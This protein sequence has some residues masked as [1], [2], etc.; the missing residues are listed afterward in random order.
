MANIYNDT[1]G[2]EHHETFTHIKSK[3]HPIM[4]KLRNS[5]SE[6]KAHGTTIL[7]LGVCNDIENLDFLKFFPNAEILML[8]SRK[9]RNIDG[10]KHAPLLTLIDI[11]SDWPGV[12]D[13]SPIGNCD[14]LEDLELALTMDTLETGPTAKVTMRG[15]ETLA[16]L[17][18]LSCLALVDM[19]LT[20]ISFVKDMASL[21]D[22]DF[23][24]NP[25]SN[26]AP[27]KGNANITELDLSSCGL[28]DISAIGEMP[29]LQF[30]HISDNKIKDFSPL[31]NLAKLECIT[32]SNNGLSPQEIEKWEKEFAH[33]DDVDFEDMSYE[34]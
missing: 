17:S 32:A 18:K 10:L 22:V 7:D 29:N 15:V 20:D 30:I 1:Y 6:K 16:R 26:L 31:K 5:I 3:L 11:T 4:G 9:L 24:G 27:L 21:E 28:S 19:G 2:I 12:L 25:I 34:S 13:I 33:I 23:S 14:A 8:D